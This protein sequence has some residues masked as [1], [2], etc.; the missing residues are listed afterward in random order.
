M[1]TLIQDLKYALRQLRKSPSFT[2]TA[3][4]VLALGLG[5]NIAV[6]TIVSGVLLRPLPYRDADRV[7]K[8]ELQGQMPYYSMS[9]A[10][11]LQ[12]R[13]AA[14][15]RLKMGMKLLDVPASVVGP[16]GRFQVVHFMATADFFDMLGV[17]PILGRSFRAEEDDP[18]RNRV[19]LIGEDVWR[20]MYAADPK[21][22]GKLITILG[23]TSTVKVPTMLVA[24][25]RKFVTNTW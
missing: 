7:V 5:A 4:T 24:A 13:D 21:I 3:V 2:F 19:V 14:G 23:G 16:G 15:A 12:L 10:N 1:S 18:G 25:P 11:M 6:F 9:Y 22:A 8:V 17:S 20:K